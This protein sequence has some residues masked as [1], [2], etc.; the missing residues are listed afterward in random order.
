MEV[1]CFE[2]VAQFLIVQRCHGNQNGLCDA[3][4]GSR[5]SVQW[6]TESIYILIFGNYF[7]NLKPSDSLAQFFNASHFPE[8]YQ[9]HQ[10]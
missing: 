1:E 8:L 4:P 3:S 7:E 5:V 10:K 9:G 2:E 6:A